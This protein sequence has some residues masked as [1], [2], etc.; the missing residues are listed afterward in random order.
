MCFLNEGCCA[1]DVS[2][3]VCSSGCFQFRDTFLVSFFVVD[4]YIVTTLNMLQ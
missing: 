2:L 3:T 4:K 1:F